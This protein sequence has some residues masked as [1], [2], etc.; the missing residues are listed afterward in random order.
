VSTLVV[1]AAV[2]LMV[3]LGFWQLHRK[4]WKEAEIARYEAAQT[5]GAEVPWPRTPAEYDR[6]LYHPSRVDCTEVT[7]FGAIAGRSETGQPGWSHIA[8]C[9]L[10]SGGTAEV[11]LGWSAEPADPHWR[12][13]EVT[14]WIASARRGVRLVASPPQAGLAP[15]ARPD[16]GAM[17]G[18]TPM[19]HLSYAVQWFLFATAALVIYV[20]ALR[21]K[22]RQ[23]T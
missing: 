23:D 13:G 18:T 7:G 20:L 14:G 6:A 5:S 15:L 9:R 19:G 2:A 17:S 3:S 1:A 10:H 21:K 11:A 8:H 12:G 16:P 4:Q 22:W